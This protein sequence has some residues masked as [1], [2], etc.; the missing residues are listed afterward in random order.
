MSASPYG[1]AFGRNS[2]QR[3]RI[4]NR[5]R[6]RGQAL[7]AKQYVALY[8][9]ADRSHEME[10]EGDKG[11]EEEKPSKYMT[12]HQVVEHN[13]LKRKNEDFQHVYEKEFIKRRKKEEIKQQMKEEFRRLGKNLKEFKKREQQQQQQQQQQHQQQQQQAPQAQ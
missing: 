11:K 3:G 9:P 8:K 1:N 7:N 6:L 13:R 2:G 10:V 4:D 5:H 12:R